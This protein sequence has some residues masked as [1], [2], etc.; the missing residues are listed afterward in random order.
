MENQLCHQRLQ[1]EQQTLL[2]ERMMSYQGVP[3]SVGASIVRD[4]TPDDE[5]TSSDGFKMISFP[6]AGFM[7]DQIS[8]TSYLVCKALPLIPDRSSQ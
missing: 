3:S 5:L 6:K 4:T 2:I 8:L 1:M 7:A